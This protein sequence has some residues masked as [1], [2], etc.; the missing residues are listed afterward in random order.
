MVSSTSI[1]E[2]RIYSCLIELISKASFIWLLMMN[3]SYERKILHS[4]RKDS[5]LWHSHLV[6]W[7]G[8]WDLCKYIKNIRKGFSIS[9]ISIL[10]WPQER[11]ANTFRLMRMLPEVFLYLLYLPDCLAICN[12][13]HAKQVEMKVSL[14]RVSAGSTFAGPCQ[15]RKYS[16][17]GVSEYSESTKLQALEV[18]QNIDKGECWS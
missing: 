16:L 11:C 4:F 18:T 5:S 15:V 10:S 1:E 3:L 8:S 2:K 17:T 12:R 7:T 14:R 13:W 6:A 9:I